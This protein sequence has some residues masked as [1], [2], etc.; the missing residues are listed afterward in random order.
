MSFWSYLFGKNKKAEEKK[1][2]DRANSSDKKSNI[3]SEWSPSDKVI[4]MKKHGE[5]QEEEFVSLEIKPLSYA[6]A[7]F[8]GPKLKANR[9]VNS[10][11]AVI[12]QDNDL[13]RSITDIDLTKTF[14]RYIKNAH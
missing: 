9:P 7:A 8:L 10:N 3:P 5:D 6:E 12:D 13:E 4:M 2:D 1:D 14:G 11:V